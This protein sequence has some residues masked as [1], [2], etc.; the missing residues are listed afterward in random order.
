MCRD[1][2]AWTV[3][4]P[5]CPRPPPP[6]SVSPSCPARWRDRP[7][8]RRSRTG[9]AAG[10][11]GSAEHRETH[12]ADR[13]NLIMEKSD[14][15]FITYLLVKYGFHVQREGR[16]SQSRNHEM[17]PRNVFVLTASFPLCISRN[18]SGWLYLTYLTELLHI[19]RQ[20]FT[21]HR[22]TFSVWKP[23]PSY[24]YNEL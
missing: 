5:E 7:G 24:W 3:G 22:A 4:T 2:P 21:S 23:L 20:I 15:C 12:L 1:Q 11:S 18:Y 9:P 8:P 17:N 16:L 13:E 19:V 6:S 10:S 14:F